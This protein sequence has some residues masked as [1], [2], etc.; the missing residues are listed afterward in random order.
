MD[1][2]TCTI[3]LISIL[4]SI[5][6]I[7][8]FFASKSCSGLPQK[9]I[10]LGIL[11]IL[12]PNLEVCLHDKMAEILEQSKRTLHIH[13]Y[14]WLTGAKILV[15][16]DPANVRHVMSTNFANYPKGLKWREHMDVLGDTLFSADLGEWEHERKLA[17]CFLSHHKFHDAMTKIVWDRIQTGLIPVLQHVSEKALVVDLQDLFQKHILDIAWI[18][19]IGYNPNSLS[20]ESQKDLFSQALEDVCE[21]AFTRF[22]IP[23][24]LWKLHRWLGI[25]KE[26]KLK[27]AWETIDRVFEDC[28]SKKDDDGFNYQAFYHPLFGSAA[29]RKGLRDNVISLI[30]ATQDTTSSVLTWFFYSVAKHPYAEAKIRD[31][32]SESSPQE[33]NKLVYLH[34]AL[35]ETL[36]LYP[37]G[38]V[39]SRTAVEAD[40]L[41]SGHRIE[42]DTNVVIAVHAMGRMTSVWGDDCHEFKPERWITEHGEIK[43][44]PHYQFLAFSA[45]PRICLGKELAFTMMKATAA[46]IIYNY[47]IRIVKDHP[48]EPKNSIVFH[49]K[50]GLMARIN[51]RWA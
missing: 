6:I 44:V 19:S 15:T 4:A 3:L 22:L 12:F 45:G 47:N 21:A 17:R 51:N 23:H 48:A 1:A 39:L 40:T 27:R 18:M 13:Q 49:M 33:L 16:S 25:G 28:M 36:R 50:H 5:I 20:T 29:T 43:R 30:F 41:P 14:S 9:R 34:A 26:K 2:F 46:T 24:S 38:P 32:I 42:R 37:P 35:C 31:E 8:L 10:L 11:S 7:I